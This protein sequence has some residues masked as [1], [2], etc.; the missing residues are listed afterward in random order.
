MAL[1]ARSQGR[2]SAEKAA[3]AGKQTGM[4][5]TRHLTPGGSEWV[6]AT[7]RHMSLDEKIGQRLF[8]TYHGSF[9]ST[10]PPPY[11]AMLHSSNHPHAPRFPNL[12]LSHPLRLL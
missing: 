8:A 11:P 6:E 1:T 12:T 10:R 5:N 3:T 7:L 9:T 2:S 4:T